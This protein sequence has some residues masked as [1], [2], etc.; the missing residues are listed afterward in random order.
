LATEW[1]DPNA[2]LPVL[3]RLIYAGACGLLPT[4]TARDHKNP[5]APDHPRLSAIR[6]L[7]L[8]E[9][10]GLPLPTALAGWLM[11]FPPEWLQCA[12]SATPS[13]P[14]SRRRGCASALL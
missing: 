10:F 9:T 1:P 3:L 4:V 5:G 8:P 7:P 12:P 6:G 11:G 2:R 13:T 14:G